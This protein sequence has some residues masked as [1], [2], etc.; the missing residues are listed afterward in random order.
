MKKVDITGSKFGLLTAL[1]RKVIN[2]KSYYVC[3]CECG[4]K[5]LVQLW[6]LKDNGTIS[7]G[8]QRKKNRTKHNLHNTK[9]YKVWDGIKQRCYNPNSNF[10]A[11]YGGRGIKMCDRWLN[12]PELF[13]KD[14]GIRPSNKHSIDRID[15]NGNYE[16]SNVRWATQKEQ[17]R[18]QRKNKLIINLENGVFHYSLIEA[19]ETYNMN[20]SSLEYQLKHAKKNKTNLILL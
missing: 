4:N 13:I 8:C 18:N 16:P 11:N 19:A 5:K 3:L 6:H 20:D 1:E 12:S 14:M 7:C 2:K 15:N 17:C 9:L 10:Y